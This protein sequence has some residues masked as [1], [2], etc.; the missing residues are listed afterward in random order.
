MSLAISIVQNDFIISSSDSAVTLFVDE[1][2]IDSLRESGFN[3]KLGEMI[4]TEGKSEKVIP[5]TDKVFL[6]TC[7]NSVLTSVFEIELVNSLQATDDLVVSREVSQRVLNN[8][9]NGYLQHKDKVLL[10]IKERHNIPDKLFPQLKEQFTHDYFMNILPKSGKV[11]EL[12]S[13]FSAYLIGFNNDGTTGMVDIRADSYT[14]GPKDKKSAYPV[15]TDGHHPGF[16]KNVESFSEY[17]RDLVLPSQYRTLENFI[18]AIT[19]VHAKISKL[20]PVNVSA[21]CNFH[22]LTKS[23]DEIEHFSFVV[24]TSVLHDEL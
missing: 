5:M 2:N 19:F 12:V 8:M 1:R 9:M 13:N 17:Q 15:L 24:D 11:T 3:P 10:A 6:S 4:P 23:N 18:K 7:G 21:D 20:S 22:V 16:N 14:E